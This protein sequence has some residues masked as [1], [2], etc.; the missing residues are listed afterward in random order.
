[1]FEM[2]FDAQST[3]TRYSG[4]FALAGRF[5]YF[6]PGANT[7]I[8]S[9]NGTIATYYSYG[10]IVADFTGVVDGPSF[11]QKFFTGPNQ[12]TLG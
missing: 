11:F 4:M 5:G 12:G 6:Y 3:Q 9:E 10:E 2:A 7:T 1:M 8:E